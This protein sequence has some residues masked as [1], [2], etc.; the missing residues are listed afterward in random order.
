M[1]GAKGLLS[2]GAIEFLSHLR[3]DVDPELYQSV[4]NVIHQLL[5]FPQEDAAGHDQRCLYKEHN[6]VEQIQDHSG[7]EQSSGWYS[8]SWLLVNFTL[9]PSNAR[10]FYWSMP[11]DSSG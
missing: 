9:R 8:V 10:Q 6:P 1:S 3:Q 5:S 4:D 11:R 7:S 2:I